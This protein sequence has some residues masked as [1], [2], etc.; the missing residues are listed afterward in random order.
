MESDQGSYYPPLHQDNQNGASLAHC[1]LN[2]TVSTSNNAC[3]LDSE[4]A[5][6]YGEFLLH[7]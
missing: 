4:K 5:A 7:H 3:S 1:G 6:T 2:Q